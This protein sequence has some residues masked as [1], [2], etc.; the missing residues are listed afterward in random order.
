[1]NL[2]KYIDYAMIN[3]LNPM[4]CVFPMPGSWRDFIITFFNS[5][6]DF[7]NSCFIEFFMQ[8]ILISFQ[9]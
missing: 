7:L 6:F 8:K 2:G 5:R 9:K 4:S 1:M 3:D